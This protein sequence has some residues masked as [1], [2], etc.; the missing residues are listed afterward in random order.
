MH[1]KSLLSH[2]FTPLHA[3]TFIRFHLLPLLLLVIRDRNYVI[4]SKASML[5]QPSINRYQ[6][7]GREQEPVPAVPGRAQAPA[8]GAWRR[9]EG[10]PLPRGEVNFLLSN[11]GS[12]RKKRKSCSEY[13]TWY[14]SYLE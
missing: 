7:Q 3:P 9:T 14:Y 11:L 13:C 1:K 2:A 8:R 12:K 10:G 5:T 4:L 6:G